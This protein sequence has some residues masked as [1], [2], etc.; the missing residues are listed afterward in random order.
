[1]KNFQ[2][3]RSSGSAFLAAL[4]RL[5]SLFLLSYIRCIDL[6]TSHSQIFT[7]SGNITIKAYTKTY[8]DIHWYVSAS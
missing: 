5:W 7:K 3:N 6:V 2:P 8:V 1:V 4:D